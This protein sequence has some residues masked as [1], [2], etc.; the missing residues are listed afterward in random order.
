MQRL[1]FKHFQL[2]LINMKKILFLSFAAFTFFGCQSAQPN[3]SQQPVSGGNSNQRETQTVAA[4]TT[5]NSMPPSVPKSENRTKWTQ[6]GNPIDTSKFDAEIKQAENKLKANPK[7]ENLKKTLAESYVSR[8]L[9]L[10]DARQY[11]SALGD[12]RRALKIDPNNAE[13]KQWIDQIIE[14]YDGLNKDYPKEGEEPPPLPFGKEKSSA[15]ERID[16]KKGATSA[17]AKGALKNYDDEK[18]FVIELKARQTLRTEQIKED[19]SLK[20]ITV[21]ITDPQ[22]NPVG[23]SDASCNNRKEIKP[24]VAGDYKI[25]VFECRKADAWQGEFQLKVSAE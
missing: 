20:Y 13:A 1:I 9:A 23:D 15:D 4:H 3:I 24:T 14:I 18:T 17:I 2:I 5:E 22:G 21:G 16:F 11:A 19:D 8:G 25:R 10:T 6:S 7:D 12:Y